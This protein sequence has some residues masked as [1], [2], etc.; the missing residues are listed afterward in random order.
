MFN[1]P[2][3]PIEYEGS[4]SYRCVVRGYFDYTP[5]DDC[6]QTYFSNPQ[7]CKLGSEIVAWLAAGYECLNDFGLIDA[8]VWQAQELM[9]AY[10]PFSAGECAALPPIIDTDGTHYGANRAMIAQGLSQQYN[11]MPVDVGS[12]NQ[13]RS[14]VKEYV[15]RIA[16][17]KD[18]SNML[19]KCN[20]DELDFS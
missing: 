19:I 6:S 1:L 17:R 9:A 2:I 12:F 7:A 10:G 11:F 13:V 14:G 20:T 5:A 8:I 18:G 4:A 16:A 15:Y 3:E